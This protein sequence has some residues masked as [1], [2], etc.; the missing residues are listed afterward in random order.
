MFFVANMSDGI[1]G[2]TVFVESEIEGASARFGLWDREL[3][4]MRA[5]QPHEISDDIEK[6]L[7]VLEILIEKSM[8][9]YVTPDIFEYI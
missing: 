1:H 8:G 4:T 3:G 2:L 5:V 9:T 7:L 6:L